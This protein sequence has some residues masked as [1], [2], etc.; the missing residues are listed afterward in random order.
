MN[1]FD[2][3]RRTALFGA[4]A[5]TLGVSGWT[6]WRQNRPP[7]IVEA[8]TPAGP[9]RARS[10][11]ARAG[12][13]GA[14]EPHDRIA[15]VP[16]E[17][18]IDPFAVRSWE[19]PPTPPPTPEPQAPAPDPQAPPLPFRYLGRQESRGGEGAAL[20]FLAQGTEVH[21]VRAGERLGP[22]HRFD[23]VGAGHLRFTYLPLSTP[24]TL[25]MDTN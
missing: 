11:P 1:R 16:T 18:I 9:D 3:A 8:A 19:P 25:M 23:G 22:D 20:Y 5:A 2:R 15:A 10:S 24:Q 21:A 6:F 12:Q 7:A 13:P 4:L 14:G 17:V